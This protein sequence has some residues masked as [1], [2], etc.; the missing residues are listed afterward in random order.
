M[1]DG[2]PPPVWC[3]GRCEDIVEMVI[4]VA[5]MAEDTMHGIWCVTDAIAMMKRWGQGESNHEEVMKVIGLG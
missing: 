2:P 3:C 1:A 4:G 5:A